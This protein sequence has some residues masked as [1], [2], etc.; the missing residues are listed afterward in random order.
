LHLKLG[1]VDV[2]GSPDVGLVSPG[3]AYTLVAGTY[4]FSE[5]PNSSYLPVFSGDCDATGNI[6]LTA[7]QIATCTLTNTDISPVPGGD[8]QLNQLSTTLAPLISIIKIPTPLA[9]PGGPGSVVYNYTV[10]NPGIV[11]LSNVAVTDNKCSPLTFVSGDI[12]NNGMLDTNEIWHYTC[13]S[14]LSQ[15]TTNAATATGQANGLTALDVANATVVVS[16]PGLPNTGVVPPLIHIIKKP[17]VFTVPYNGVVTYTYVVSNPGVVPLNN[18]SVADDKCSP[19]LGHSGDLNQNNLLDPSET[20]TYTCQTNLTASTT[21][22]ATAE[23]SANGLN[24]LD[25][26]VATV[27]V[28]VPG[29]PKTGYPPKQNSN[30]LNIIILASILILTSTSIVVVLKKRTQ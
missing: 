6:T 22:T 17:S 19:V 20:W 4:V 7:G 27:L 16:V 1:G 26:S 3:R 30:P 18:V 25:Y 15:T 13:T 23:G 14:T 9:L 2:A 28:P 24:A 29:L 8:G 12:N 11:A 10:S 21:N 5:D